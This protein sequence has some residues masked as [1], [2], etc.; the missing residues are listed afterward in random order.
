MVIKKNHIF[1][2][3]NEVKNNKI[4]FNQLTENLTNILNI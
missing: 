4:S 3:I 2:I 1:K